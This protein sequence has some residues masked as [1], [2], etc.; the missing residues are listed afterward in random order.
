M[1]PVGNADFASGVPAVPSRDYLTPDTDILYGNVRDFD[2]DPSAV[3]DISDVREVSRPCAATRGDS[4]PTDP[5][6]NA[7]GVLAIWC[8]EPTAPIHAAQLPTLVNPPYTSWE[9]VVEPKEARP[10]SHALTIR[11][12][13][14][15]DFSAHGLAR[16]GRS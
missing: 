4:T 7:P 3:F 15:F 10:Q 14:H 13:Q 9:P 2:F 5:R 6:M 12:I 11:L 16:R 8:R 1:V